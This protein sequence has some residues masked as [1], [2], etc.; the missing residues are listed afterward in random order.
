MN[1]NG[2]VLNFIVGDSGKDSAEK[3]SQFGMNGSFICYDPTIKIIISNGQKNNEPKE[4]Q[5]EAK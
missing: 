2:N 4:L 3:R 5:K 1:I